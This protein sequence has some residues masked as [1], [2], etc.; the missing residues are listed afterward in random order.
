MILAAKFI[1]Q[2]FSFLPFNLVALSSLTE[3]LTGVSAHSFRPTLSQ[4][5]AGTQTQ[6]RTT[7]DIARETIALQAAQGEGGHR[8]VRG[9][10]LSLRVQGE[11]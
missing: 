1:T 11:L 4:L 10:I 6:H 8:R 9:A 5:I 2:V 7:S 3:R